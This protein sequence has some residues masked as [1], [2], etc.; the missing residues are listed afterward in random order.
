M[1]DQSPR[2]Q[3]PDAGAALA[4]LARLHREIDE[5]CASLQSRHASRLRCE[6]GCSRC[7][8]DDLTVFEVEAERIRRA[9]PGLLREGRPHDSGSCAFLDGDGA[10]RVY[11]ARPYV[12]RTQGL[13][14]RWLEQAEDGSGVELRDICPLNEDRAVPLELLDVEDCWTIGPVE[15]ELARLQGIFGAGRMTRVALRSLFARAD[16]D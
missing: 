13:P 4:G 3:R 16:S 14:L 15:Q 7:C 11:A 12:C 10:C 5:R 1:T 8:V 9:H 2:G 6:R